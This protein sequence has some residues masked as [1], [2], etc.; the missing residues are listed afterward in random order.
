[1]LSRGRRGILS[2]IAVLVVAGVLAAVVWGD[3]DPATRAVHRVP[4][5]PVTVTP[6]RAAA[7]APGSACGAATAPTVAAVQ[8]NVAQGI[9]RDELHGHEAVTDAARVAGDAALLSALASGDSA[10]VAGEVHAIVYKPAWHIVRLRVTKTGGRVVADVGGPY[11]IAPIEG[12]LRWHGRTVGRYVMSV[13]DD[14]GYVKLITRFIGAPIEIYQH[15]GPLMGTL[16]SP[17]SPPSDGQIL[18]VAGRRYRATV[19]DA[20]AMPTGSLRIAIFVPAATATASCTAVR[21]AAWGSVAR[22]IAARFNPLSAHYSDFAS[23]VRAVTG[24]R[25]FVREGSTRLVGAG[26][27]HLP[28]TGSVRYGGRTWPVYSWQPAPSQ[29]IYF[30]TPPA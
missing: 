21:V 28:T 17:P 20:R 19:L 13:Q 27:A 8:T 18:T 1:M 25:V 3:P 23:V 5:A 26:P 11:I 29:R 6:A 12:S 14:A 22:H 15:G 9:Y 4:V 24:G 7:A 30:L 10:T 2:L 16:V